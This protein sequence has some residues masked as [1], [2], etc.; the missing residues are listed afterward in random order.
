[1]IYNNYI[2]YFN[3]NIIIIKKLDP[4]LIIIIRYK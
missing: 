2:H 4:N 3:Y 1:M